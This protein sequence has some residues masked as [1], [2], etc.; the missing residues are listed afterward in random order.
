VD[1]AI[2]A[3]DNGGDMGAGKMFDGF[4]DFDHAQYEDEA[5]ER[6]GH[7]DAWKESKRRTKDYTK[8]DWTRIREEADAV[9][10]GLADLLGR[11][12]P[13]DSSEAMAVAEQHRQH[14][15]RWFY[16]CSRAMHE[17]IAEMYTADPR[18]EASFEKRASGLAAY[19]QAAIRANAARS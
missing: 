11:G 3:L 2:E 18:F 9:M 10:R 12:H 8:A 14:I 5:R 7:T 16:P 4:E 15:D 13:A 19:A 17:R 1:A 6:W